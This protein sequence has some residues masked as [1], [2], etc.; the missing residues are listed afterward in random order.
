MTGIILV[1]N[2]NIVLELIFSI[3]TKNVFSSSFEQTYICI[4]VHSYSYEHFF[5]RKSK[6]KGDVSRILKFCG[7]GS[8]FGNHCFKQL[9]QFVNKFY[10]P[11]Q[12]LSFLRS[13]P[14]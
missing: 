9:I 5:S 12:C 8:N 4:R 2:R 11:R 6:P 3:G 1:K 14:S 10:T 7:V 13:T